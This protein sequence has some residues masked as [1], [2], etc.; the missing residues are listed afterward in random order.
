MMPDSSSV[1]PGNMMECQVRCAK[2]SEWSC[3]LEAVCQL[4]SCRKDQWRL[5]REGP[6]GGLPVTASGPATRRGLL[7]SS[8]LLRSHC[9]KIQPVSTLP[10]HLCPYLGHSIKDAVAKHSKVTRDPKWEVTGPL[11][12]ATL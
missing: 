10:G 3:H 2:C 1:H 9:G 7:S 8:R 4:L 11:S 6:K 12:S 5:E